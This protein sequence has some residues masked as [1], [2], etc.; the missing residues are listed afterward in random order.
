[1]ALTEKQIEAALVATGGFISHTAQM[2][3][4][5]QVAIYKRISRSKAL[6]RARADI[7]ESQ[8]D[9]AESKL[10]E[11]IKAGDLGAICFY[12]K[13]KGKSRGYVE[14]QTVIVKGDESKPVQVKHDTTEQLIKAVDDI[15]MGR[16]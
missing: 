3:K 13:C 6:T 9:I 12:L 15:L 10:I 14:R 7:Q 16:R 1:M 11:K 5:S 4:V 2:L 8:L